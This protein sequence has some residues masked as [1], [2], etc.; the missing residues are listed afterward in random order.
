MTWLAFLGASTLMQR[1]RAVR[2]RR[3]VRKRNRQRLASHARRFEETPAA[4]TC[5]QPRRVMPAGFSLIFAA[6]R[7]DQL[8]LMV[9]ISSRRPSTRL[10]RQVHETPIAVLGVF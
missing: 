6:Q 10:T 7:G 8:A 1:W 9:G 2:W 5:H 3:S 4:A